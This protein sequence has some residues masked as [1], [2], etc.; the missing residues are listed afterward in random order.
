[1]I[2]KRKRE[3]VAVSRSTRQDA[4]EG[5]N[6]DGSDVFR[7]Y[8]ESM[9]EPLPEVQARSEGESESS[10]G[11]LSDEKSDWEGFSER[12]ASP[13]IVQVIEHNLESAADAN[14]RS[15]SE[16]KAFM[17]SLAQLRSKAL[18]G[19]LYAGKQ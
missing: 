18:H 12:S 16:Y 7:K 6:L 13:P 14:T 5:G 3:A 8:F 2:G 1:M 9:F 19:K 17:V 11:D 15:S 4:D 10:Q